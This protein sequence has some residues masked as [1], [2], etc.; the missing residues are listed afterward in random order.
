MWKN[1]NVRGVIKNYVDFS[2]NLTTVQISADDK[3]A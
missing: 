1:A 2:P 3:L